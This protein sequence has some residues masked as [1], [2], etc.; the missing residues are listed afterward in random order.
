MRR[1]TRGYSSMRLDSQIV[2][3]IRLSKL[4]ERNKPILLPIHE[5]VLL[6]I[7]T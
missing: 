7:E 1:N 4:V 3:F 6:S 2:I 5:N